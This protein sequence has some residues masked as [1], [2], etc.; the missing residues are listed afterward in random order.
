MYNEWIYLVEEKNNILLPRY[1]DFWC[2]PSF[3][4]GDVIID[5]TPR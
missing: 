1:L 5:I 2:I 4:I 3:K